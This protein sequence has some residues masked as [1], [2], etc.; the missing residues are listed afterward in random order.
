MGACGFHWW[1]EHCQRLGG[2]HAALTQVE[3]QPGLLLPG[4]QNH[5][6]E[7]QS[8]RIKAVSLW[9]RISG[10]RVLMDQNLPSEKSQ[11]LFC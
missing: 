2:F 6:L 4:L 1:K 8:L 5:L 3:G 11:I 9:G 7:E 10:L